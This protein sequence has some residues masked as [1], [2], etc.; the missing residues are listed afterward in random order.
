MR[1]F[2]LENSAGVRYG[3]N[4]E[5]GIWLD[6]PTGLGVSYSPKWADFKNGF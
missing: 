2:Y 4:G 3:L 6:S 1:K 5:N